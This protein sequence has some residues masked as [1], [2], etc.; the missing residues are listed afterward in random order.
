MRARCNQPTTRHVLRAW[1]GDVHNGT[2][3]Y[4]LIAEHGRVVHLARRHYFSTMTAR[5]E[6]AV[7]LLLAVFLLPLALLIVGASIALCIRGVNEIVQ[8][9]S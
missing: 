9:F 1:A 7:L 4:I 3:M 6:D 5:I 2:D 8:L